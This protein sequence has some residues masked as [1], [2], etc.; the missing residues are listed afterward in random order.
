MPK[1]GIGI[2][3]RANWDVVLDV[4][5]QAD[6]VELEVELQEGVGREE[7]VEY[8]YPR[9]CYLLRI[10]TLYMA[11]H[12][13]RCLLLFDYYQVIS[14]GWTRAVWRAASTGT[15]RSVRVLMSSR[16]VMLLKMVKNR[17]RRSS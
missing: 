3:P 8:C 2:R 7:L 12:L 11:S 6:P 13:Q 17:C 9:K 4:R 1:K 15:P 5:G 10:V 14:L 16:V